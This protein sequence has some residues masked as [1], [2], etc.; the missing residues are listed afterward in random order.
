MSDFLRPE[1][2]A[3]LWRWR[4]V[5]IAMALLALGLWWGLRSF[6]ILSWIGY[7]IAVL[8]I[9]I[10]LAGVQ[11]TRFRR[12]SGG[13]GVVQVTEG[14]IAYFGPLT[15]GV[16]DL[17]DLTRLAL[18]ATG[19]PAS[20]WILTSIG[21]TTLSIPVDAEGNEAL[22]DVFAALP[23]IETEKMLS[24]LSRTERAHV[25]I[26]EKQHTRLH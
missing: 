3:A 19:G 14:K 6:G 23:G 22:F 20:H 26:W 17:D 10:A 18:D 16:A 21:G 1:A 12:G 11:R 15:G 2:R 13:Q 9:F 24:V 5:I 8:A 25:V 7:A 4:E